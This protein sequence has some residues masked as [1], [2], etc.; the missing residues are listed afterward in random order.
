MYFYNIIRSIC[1]LLYL[2]MVDHNIAEEGFGIV[3]Y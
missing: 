2:Y 3:G 1:M